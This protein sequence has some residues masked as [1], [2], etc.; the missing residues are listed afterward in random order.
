MH[1]EIVQDGPGTCPICGM[2]L[3]PM[4]IAAAG[5][6]PNPELVDFTRRLKIGAALT[7]PLVLLAMAP[8]VGISLH[9][10]FSP[11]VGQLIELA[12][13]TPVVLWCALPF[14]ERG[15]ASIE[16]R[17]P[18]MWTLISLGVGAAYL[19]SLAAVAAP[20]LFPAEMRGHGGSVGVYFEASAVI[21]VLVLAGQILELKARERTGHAI[22]ALLDLAPK[23]AWKIGADGRETSVPLAG[24]VVG[25]RLRVRPGDAVPLDGVIVE[26]RSG[27]DETLLTG[28]PMPVE[29]SSGDSVTGGTINTTGTFVME[30]QRVGAETTL[31]RIV[32]MVSQSQRSRAP[33]QN[34]VDRIAAWFVPAVVAIALLAF[35]GWL[36]WGPAPS[37]AYAVVAAVSVLIIACPCA[38]G[39]ATP[40]SVMVATGRGAR[41]GVLIR[42]AA[43]LET[44]AGVDTLVVDKT[45]TLTEG[46]PA[47]VAVRAQ[48]GVSEDE[49][50]T[51]AASLE[52]GS[53]HPLA[54]AIVRAAEDK[55]LS[56]APIEHFTAVPGQG[57]SG[58]IGGR[59][60]MLGSL[61]FLEQQKIATAATADTANS[62]SAR[63]RTP[64]AVALDGRLAGL[65]TLADPIK[66][67]AV[68]ALRAL[69]AKGIEVEMAT[70][71]AQGTASAVASELGIAKVAAA[72]TP[73]GKAELVA[74]LKRE[75]RK[76]AF[77][78]DG[79]NDAPAL[80]EADVGIAMGTGADVAIE[81]AG[82][83][84]P[85]GDLMAI[86]RA[87]ALAEATLANIR[88]NLVFAFGYNAI[89]IPIAAGVLYPA[90]G[91][92]LSP[93]LAALAMSLSSVSV[94]ANALRLG[95]SLAGG[96]EPSQGS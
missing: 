33:V 64:L 7:I 66:P 18:N 32:A 15:L 80:A 68:A 83:V 94:I 73:A 53:E 48:G 96:R 29:K 88:Q 69:A 12:L 34:L 39:L 72:V 89:G 14:F 9:G 28:E 6:A 58:S 55:G 70:G 71:D 60:V 24:I 91:L 81:S 40:V 42:Q 82:I 63:G 41:H 21:V 67:S 78:G 1:P 26:G 92:L 27:I 23:T 93:M 20:G 51:F 87:R 13:A 44:L 86:V 62:E 52:R 50:L 79:I 38:L 57:V 54:S 65:L 37:L 22:R 35:V 17:S 2:A 43:A 11:R 49:L 25:D 45:G 77:A 3:E 59:A 90:F 31:A 46:R 61:A 84:L 36:L 19:Y 16:N 4:D 30:A 5:D 47:L 8:H 85:K 56:L 75:G 95:R 10:L 76:V 74:R